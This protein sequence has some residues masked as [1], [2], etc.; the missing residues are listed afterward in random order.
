MKKKITIILFFFICFFC[1]NINNVTAERIL[2]CVYEFH[3]DGEHYQIVL[4]VTGNNAFVRQ[5]RPQVRIDRILVIPSPSFESVFLDDQGYL[6]CAFSVHLSISWWYIFGWTPGQRS[7]SAW[8]QNELSGEASNRV[9]RKSP[10]N[11]ILQFYDP[12]DYWVER[13]ELPPPE[14]IDCYSIFGG[15]FGQYL[16]QGL[17]F[18]HYLAPVLLLVLTIIDYIKAITSQDQDTIKKA[19]STFVKRMIIVA[20][21]F[22][23]GIVIRILLGII[24]ITDP[25]CYL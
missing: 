18:L 9:V 20:A 4:H 6:Q 19:N 24:G 8:V 3:E 2:K 15:N 23:A 17:A 12:S 11:I 25:N 21:I 13:E 22:F 10:G 5:I 1:V 14:E 16:R 7:A